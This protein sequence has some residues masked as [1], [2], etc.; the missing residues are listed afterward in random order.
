[1]IN[2]QRYIQKP[3]MDPITIKEIAADCF[4]TDR[5]LLRNF[6]S[7]TGY[8][9]KEYIQQVRIQKAREQIETTSMR[10]EQIA[11]SVGYEDSS[12][13]R[14]LFKKLTGLAPGEY[15]SRFVS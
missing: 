11:L 2:A 9:P 13:F 12:A 1:M 5:T 4:V 7:A 8:T 3:Y 6:V 15:R 10:I 14:K